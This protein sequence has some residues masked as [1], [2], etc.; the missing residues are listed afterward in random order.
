[1]PG[2]PP[3]SSNVGSPHGS[4]H[5]LDGMGTRFGNTLDEKLDA[6]L[7]KICTLRNADR[8]NSC[9]HDMDVP[10]GFTYLETLGDFATRL[11][12]MEQNFSALTARM[13]KI[14]T[15][16][17]SAS[18]VSGSARSWPT[19]KQVDGSTAGGSHGPGSSDDHRNTR[20]RLDTSSSTDDEQS[21]SAVLQRFPCEQY[22]QGITKWIDTLWDESNM[23]TCNKPFRIHCKA[24]SVSVRLV[25]ETRDKCQDFVAQH[26]DDG[27]PCAINS[28]F[29]RP[30]TPVTVRQ[31]RSIEDREIGKQ[32]APL[33]KVLAE[34]LKVLF[35]DEE[36]AASKIV[37]TELENR[38]SSLLHLV[39]DKSLPLLHLI[40]LFLVFRLRCCNRFS[41]K[42]TGLMCDGCPLASPLFR[43]LA[44]RGL[45]FF[46]FL[47]RWV[48][49]LAA[50]VIPGFTE[51]RSSFSFREDSLDDCGRPC[52]PL[53]CLLFSALW[54][55]CSPTIL[56]QETP[57]VKNVDTTCSTTSLF[58]DATCL[59]VGPMS[60]DWPVH[61]CGRSDPSG[62]SLPPGA[63]SGAQ[64]R[65]A[66]P[67]IGYSRWRQGALHAQ[68]QILQ[69]ATGWDGCGPFLSEALRC[70]TWNTRGLVG[71]VFT[72]QR[73]T[74][75]KLNYLKQLL[76]NNIICLQ[77]V[78]GKD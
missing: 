4:G 20:R 53:S 34:Q 39:V 54:L 73:N 65:G 18:N 76:D 66:F 78:H 44:G 40:C 38:F 29:C 47:L 2:S 11:S 36:D 30:S 64:Q 16:T 25:F 68:A 57:S 52:D 37:E 6:F 60:L 1:M 70:I 26:K 41:L 50:F 69:R 42:P 14:E 5:D 63:L 27:I 10:Y 31:S 75:S 59:P 49:H 74:E 19:L 9:S 35:P 13:C 55:R 72:R 12:E 67:A 45:F 3:L 56:V 32:F 17:A 7:S 62:P 58:G 21:R 61:P 15:Y 77:E 23:Q 48:L 8:S 33:W 46:W 71:S 43:R 28:P 51:H 22:L 24:G